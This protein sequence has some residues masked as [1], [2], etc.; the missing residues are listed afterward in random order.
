[1][2][3]LEKYRHIV[4]LII[5]TGIVFTIALRLSDMVSALAAVYEAFLPLLT[6]IGMAFV[7]NIIVASFERFYFP[8]KTSPWVEKSRRPICTLLAL[9]SVLVIITFVLWM[10]IPQMIH[11]ISVIVQALPELHSDFNT[12]FTERFQHMPYGAAILDAVSSQS[13]ISDLGKLGSDFGRRFVSTMG[14]A[15]GMAFNFFIGLVFAVYI[16]L[17]KEHLQHQFDQ[18]GRAYLPATAVGRMLYVLDV[19]NRTFSKFFIGQFLDALILGALV[20]LALFIFG[21]PYATNIGCVV[22]LMAL[23]PL[24]GAYIGAVMGI[25]M[26]LTQGPFEAMLFLIILIVIQQLE[27]HL[28]YPRIVGGSVGL[29]SI[30]VFAAVIVGGSLYGVLGILLSVPLAATVYK[31]LRADVERR[32]GRPGTGQIGSD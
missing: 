17:N 10:A 27:G 14:N 20:A 19:A 13:V 32:L 30:W 3:F 4:G 22:G 2:K 12:W 28:I 9:A 18:L 8:G 15:V 11:S 25:I 16:L 5:L 26:L 6:G 1:M 21:L 24:L 31:L 7:L 29:P 23:V